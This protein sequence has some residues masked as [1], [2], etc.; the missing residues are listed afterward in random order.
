MPFN[1]LQIW[2]E[3][4]SHISLSMVMEMALTTR[5][6]GALVLKSEGRKTKASTLYIKGSA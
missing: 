4:L 2:A 5:I 6:P 1:T 3:S